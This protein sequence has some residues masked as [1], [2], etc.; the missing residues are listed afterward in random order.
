LLNCCLFLEY[1]L[2][3]P[4]ALSSSS[5]PP[6]PPSHSVPRHVPVLASTLM[7]LLTGM[8]YIYLNYLLINEEVDLLL[9]SLFNRAEAFCHCP[10]SILSLGPQGTE[11]LDSS[12]SSRS[13]HHLL[14]PSRS[15]PGSLAEA[16]A[17]RGG[18]PSRV[19]AQSW[20]ELSRA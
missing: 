9:L 14:S 8:L 2:K 6:L 11:S 3:I 4:C 1:F 17:G 5:S 19:E 10:W 18:G 16:E 13:T 7:G 15:S 20:V 12:S